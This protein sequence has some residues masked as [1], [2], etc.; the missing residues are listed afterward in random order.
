MQIALKLLSAVM[1]HCAE[2]LH[3]AFL[4]AYQFTFQ[5]THLVLELPSAL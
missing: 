5:Q 4:T 1:P 2:D 3:Q